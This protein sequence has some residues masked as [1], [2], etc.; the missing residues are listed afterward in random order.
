M[1]EG[2]SAAPTRHE[3]YA[4]TSFTLGVATCVT[5]GAAITPAQPQPPGTGL[6]VTAGSSRCGTPQ[7]EFWLLAPGGAWTMQRPY[8]G[9]SWS[10]STAGLASGTYQVGVW[11][12]QAGSTNSYDAYFI[13]TYTLR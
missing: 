1:W 6:T 3:S 8:G 4:I 12:R 11:A 2:S 5:A 7:Y 10:W 9:A 13:G